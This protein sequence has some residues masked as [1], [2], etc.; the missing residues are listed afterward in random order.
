MGRKRVPFVLIYIS[1]NMWLKTAGTA[2]VE[3]PLTGDTPGYC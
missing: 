2:L 1:S 3:F